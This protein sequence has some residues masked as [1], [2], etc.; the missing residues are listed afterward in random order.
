MAKASGMFP[1]GKAGQA[2]P[3]GMPRRELWLGGGEEPEWWGLRS[4]LKKRKSKQQ[5]GHCSL[6][7][8]QDTLLWW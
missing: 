5:K 2:G 4:P 3:E 8:L 7:P 1:E 6:H